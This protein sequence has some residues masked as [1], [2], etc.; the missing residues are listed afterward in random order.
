MRQHC[1][2]MLVGNCIGTAIYIVSK[3]ACSRIPLA[4]EV[5]TTLLLF[6]LM[7]G[8]IKLARYVYLTSENTKRWLLDMRRKRFC[9]H[10]KKNLHVHN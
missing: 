2:Q 7:V 6:F 9:L 1:E 8:D 3:Q 4:L 10:L 5:N